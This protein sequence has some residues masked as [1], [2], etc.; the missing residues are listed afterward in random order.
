[1]S[2]FYGFELLREQTLPEITSHSRLYRHARTGAELL[3]LTND[4]RNKTFG[5]TFRI[6]PSDDTGVA[7]VLEHCML[8]GI[9]GSRKYPVKE[10]YV[11]L[12]KGSLATF[13]NGVM[14]FD[15]TIYPCASQNLQDFYNLM[16]VYL[17]AL[18][19]PRLDRHTFEQEGWHYELESADAP[20]TYRGVVCNEVK[21]GYATADEV[22]PARPAVLCFRIP[23]MDGRSAV[24][25]GISPT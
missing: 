18:L 23:S 1:M 24:I 15:K 19:H 2:V 8:L 10:L 13:I 16:E 21:I 3:A 20:L 17:D 7:H 14:H 4:D 12:Q 9:G 6:V 25:H 11:E 22:L 5:V